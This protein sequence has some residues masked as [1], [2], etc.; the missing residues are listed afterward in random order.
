MN[1]RT[2]RLLRD[3]GEATETR[4]VEG[5]VIEKGIPV[6]PPFHN[7][8][9]RVVASLEVGE[10]FVWPKEPSFHRKGFAPRKFSTKRIGPKQFRVWR[11]A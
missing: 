11:I 10:S 6:P 9:L 8:L 1:I 7:G 3:P 4:V 5:V 2:V